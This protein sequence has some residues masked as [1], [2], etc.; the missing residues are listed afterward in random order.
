LP[1]SWTRPQAQLGAES[2]DGE[3]LEEEENGFLRDSEARADLLGSQPVEPQV[4]QRGGGGALCERRVANPAGFA[5]R[6]CG[7]LERA[8]S[9]SEAFQTRGEAAGN[10]LARREGRGAL[11]PLVDS[12]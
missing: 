12:I 11:N 6:L 3:W 5:E 7:L 2:A 4:G 10:R 8:V 9:R 1:A